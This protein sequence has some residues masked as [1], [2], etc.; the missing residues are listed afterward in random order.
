MIT[1]RTLI[2]TAPDL[3][4]IT[5]IA[6]LFHDLSE[7]LELKSSV[8]VLL[9]V[10]DQID[11]L[12]LLRSPIIDLVLDIIKPRYLFL[13]LGQNFELFNFASYRFR[14]V[15]ELELV[16]EDKLVVHLFFRFSLGDRQRWVEL[17]LRRVT[18]EELGAVAE[19][20][21]ALRSE[22]V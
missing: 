13:V 4:V 15:A 2:D 22:L 5:V 1:S 21:V 3:Q 11:T 9:R 18:P 20:A 16:G 6:G 19:D 17:S 12:E 8:N 10:K 7:L 14:S